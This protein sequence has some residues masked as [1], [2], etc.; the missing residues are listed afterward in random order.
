MTADFCISQLLPIV[1]E[2][3]SSSDYKPPNDV[4]A[5][6]ESKSDGAESN[7]LKLP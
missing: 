7:L 2:I 6:F 3:Q 5:L 1:H 4:R